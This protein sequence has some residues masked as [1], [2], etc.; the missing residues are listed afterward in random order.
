MVHGR[1]RKGKRGTEM[2]NNNNNNMV[3]HPNHYAEGRKYEPIKVIMDWELSFCLGNVLKYISR[4]GRKGDKLEDLL[5]ARE[6][7]NFEIEEMQKGSE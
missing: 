5:K 1:W 4:A 2:E 6:Y 7:L 3:H